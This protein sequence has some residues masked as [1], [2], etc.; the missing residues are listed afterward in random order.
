MAFCASNLCVM[1]HNSGSVSH[2]SGIGLQQ[3]CITP[4][5]IKKTNPPIP[6]NIQLSLSSDNNVILLSLD[7]Q[8]LQPQL[9]VMIN[10]P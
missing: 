5:F 2:N 8:I 9:P 1:P 3:E 6:L 7:G 4:A 10:F